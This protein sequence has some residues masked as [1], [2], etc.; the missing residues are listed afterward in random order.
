MRRGLCSLQSSEGTE[1]TVSELASTGLPALS[2][3]LPTGKH[4]AHMFLEAI[5]FF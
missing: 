5:F 4:Q 3:E 2:L 1:E